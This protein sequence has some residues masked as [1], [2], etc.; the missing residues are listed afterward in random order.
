[1]R[2]SVLVLSIFALTFIGGVGVVTGASGAEYSYRVNG[3]MLGTG[4][5]KPF[6]M[7]AKTHQVI[8]ATVAGIEFRAECEDVQANAV[9]EPVIKGGVPGTASKVQ[10][11]G[12]GCHVP[13][14]EVT[15]LKTSVLEGEIVTV[16]EPS[17][18]RGKLAE[19]LKATE[20]SQPFAVMNVSCI[21]TMDIRGTTALL[22][23]P[24]K[25]EQK[26]VDLIAE[27]KAHLITEIEKS[28]GTREKV[29][30]KYEGN[31]VTWEGENTVELGSG[32]SWGVF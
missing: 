25:T 26:A 10:L 17:S 29:G 2:R 30:L 27:A 20:A 22:Y 8:K 32:E 28:N 16:V 5:S 23:S 11:E 12:S 9:Q 1:M 21:G 24:E 18:E 13:D 3:T 14:C 19:M 7:K 31:S 6:A 15:S 4:Q